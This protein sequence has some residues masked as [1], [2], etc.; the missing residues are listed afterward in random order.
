M[1]PRSYPV[2]WDRL[3]VKKLS[4]IHCK[5][6]LWECIFLIENFK[7]MH[8]LFLKHIYFRI[9]QKYYYKPRW[10]MQLTDVQILSGDY[11]KCSL[12]NCVI[13]Q[14]GRSSE[15]YPVDYSIVS[16]VRG[17]APACIFTHTQ[18]LESASL[19]LLKKGY[20][21]KIPQGFL[22]I[23]YSV[24]VKAEHCLLVLQKRNEIGIQAPLA[25]Q[26]LPLINMGFISDYFI[27]STQIAP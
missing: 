5:L 9:L 2:A 3:K 25:K 14:M 4:C 6:R 1:I 23:V 17:K 26:L 12:L 18:L 27:C 11:K 10:L 19:H 15:E 8:K 24:L 20:W 16:A 7:E 21:N 22:E 13:W